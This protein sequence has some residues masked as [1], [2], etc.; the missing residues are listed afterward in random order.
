MR[1]S[2][3]APLLLLPMFFPY[4]VQAQTQNGAKPSTSVRD[5]VQGFYSWY[6]PQVLKSRKEPA[7]DLVLKYRA[8]AL[9]IGLFQALKEDSDAQAKVTGE[10]VGLDFDPFLNT[11]DPCESFEVGAVAQKGDSYRV[12]V[13]SVCSG[14]KN[15][16]PAVIAEVVRT[17]GRWVFAN[18]HYGNQIKEYPDSADLMST[19]KLLRQE[20][21]GSHK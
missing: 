18:F 5:F 20:R 13:Y 14:K 21:G 8:H 3:I 12:E 10:I 1:I 4:A 9:S 16:K 2:K 15:E 7:L 6:V 11:Q 19:L 17:G